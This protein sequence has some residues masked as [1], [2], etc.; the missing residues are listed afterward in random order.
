MPGFIARKLC[1]ELIIIHPNFEKY[2]AVS[3]RVREIFALYDPNYSMMSLD[4]AYLDFTDHV[5]WRQSTNAEER[6]L[7]GFEHPDSVCR[8]STDTTSM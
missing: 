5:T 7:M 2:T 4:E 6:T 8:C 1:P 3:E